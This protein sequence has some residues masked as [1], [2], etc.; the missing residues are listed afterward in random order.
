MLAKVEREGEVEREGKRPREGGRGERERGRGDKWRSA[1]P[2]RSS[3][4]LTLNDSFDSIGKN[5]VDEPSGIEHFSTLEHLSKIFDGKKHLVG[6]GKFGKTS[7]LR[8]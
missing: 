5:A 8:D 6:M 7:P 2:P 4:A 3:E 1:P